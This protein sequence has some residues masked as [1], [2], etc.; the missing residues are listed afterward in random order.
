MP[1]KS[2]QFKFADHYPNLFGFNPEEKL[3]G[4]GGVYNSR[5]LNLFA[6]T[7]QNPVK[8]VDPDGKRFFFWRFM[9]NAGRGAARVGGRFTRPLMAARK[10]PIP[11][12]ADNMTKPVG[13]WW[14][15]GKVKNFDGDHPFFKKTPNELTKLS[16]ETTKSG[17][18]KGSKSTKDAKE[19]KR[20][21]KQLKRADSR[22]NEK[23]GSSAPP[24]DYENYT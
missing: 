18:P 2:R 14:K 24:I 22:Y 21:I 23:S 7:I 17:S 12:W 10:P 4:K 16:K 11:K 15:G 5:N 3:P 13:E 6:Y 19:A 20:F 9:M 8:Y 1:V